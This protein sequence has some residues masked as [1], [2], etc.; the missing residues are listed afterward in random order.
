M[1]LAERRSNSRV[2]RQLA[3]RVGGG[4]GEWLTTRDVSSTGGF[5]LGDDRRRAGEVV[6]LQILGAVGGGVVVMRALV[7][8]VVSGGAAEPG[9][10]VI[11]LDARSAHLTDLLALLHDGLDLPQTS[12]HDFIGGGYT[13]EAAVRLAHASRA[14][15]G[16]AL[17]QALKRSAQLPTVSHE[18]T[19]VHG[20]RSAIAEATG[21]TSSVSVRGAQ[22]AGGVRHSDS[23]SRRTGDAHAA[24]PARAATPAAQQRATE[25]SPTATPARSSLTIS[26]PPLARDRQAERL[27]VR[28][29]DPAVAN[30]IRTQAPVTTPPTRP[31]APPATTAVAKTGPAPT[32]AAPTPAS[33]GDQGGPH[34]LRRLLS[35]TDKLRR[36]KTGEPSLGRFAVSPDGR[37]YHQGEGAIP[38]DVATGATPPPAAGLGK[39]DDTP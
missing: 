24:A 28:T 25:A 38:D 21:R 19:E 4:M 17:V 7:A 11:W 3:V 12:V 39:D 32:A 15:A 23:G 16:P 1:Q 20:F 13:F 9:M 18:P 22:H 36:G 33:S 5:V 34:L 29:T 35:L 8:R 10:G 27:T 26:D 14:S 30:P 2:S 37:F 31:A 6:E